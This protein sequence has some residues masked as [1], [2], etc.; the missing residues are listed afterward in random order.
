MLVGTIACSCGRHITWRCECGAITYGPPLTE[1]CS[2]L[3][4]PARIR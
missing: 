2:L 4:G 3:D 1:R